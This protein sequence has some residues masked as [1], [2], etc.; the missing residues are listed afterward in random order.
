MRTEIQDH[1]N[2]AVENA[3][4]G[5]RYER[6]QGDGPRVRVNDN[7]HPLF[8]RYFTPDEK[9]KSFDGDLTI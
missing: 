8:S 9:A 7:S 1:L 4:A 3:L 2:H 5:V 6:V